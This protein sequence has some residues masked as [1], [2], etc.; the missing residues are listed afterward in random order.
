MKFFNLRK[1]KTKSTPPAVQRHFSDDE[2]GIKPS[3][4]E[5]QSVILEKKQEQLTK[6]WHSEKAIY[7]SRMLDI[8]TDDIIKKRERRITP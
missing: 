5:K 4:A 6:T 1:D 7:H 8:I 2:L 3:P